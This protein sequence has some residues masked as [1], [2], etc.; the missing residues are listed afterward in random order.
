MSAHEG[1][2]GWLADQHTPSIPQHHQSAGVGYAFV[3]SAPPTLPNP[4]RGVKRALLRIVRAAQPISRADLARRMEVH[5][6]TVSDIV[7]PFLDS[8]VLSEKIGTTAT[9][10]MG[11]PP[12]ALSLHARGNAFV[13]VHLG[14]HQSHVC[15]ALADGTMLGES[16][17]ETPSNP[18]EALANIRAQIQMLKSKVPNRAIHLIGVSVPGPVDAAQRHLVYAPHLGWRDLDIAGALRFKSG[19]ISDTENNGDYV[20]VVVENDATA[21]AIYEM[22]RQL[23]DYPNESWHDFV[24]VRVGSGIGVGLIHEGAVYR[25]SGPGRGLV[26]EFG[27]MTVVADGMPCVCGNRGCWECYASANSAV[28]FYMGS[29]KRGGAASSL[30][31]LDIVRRAEA[32]EA[33]A[34]HAL[35]QVG[36]YLGIGIANVITGLGVSRVVVSGR[37]VLGWAFIERALHEEVDRSMVGRLTSWSTIAGEAVGSGLGGALEVAFEEYLASLTTETHAVA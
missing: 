19:A 17:F 2:E 7:R 35:E 36:K 21:A 22:R 24:L 5:R 4:A 8:G 1:R 23:R 12:V 32:G 33:R 37:I 25:G 16:S 20:P 29:R 15:L 26:G 27:H 6:A 11:R 10:R 13:G 14:V 31:Y 9:P 34:R 30:N 3:N 18:A 28:A